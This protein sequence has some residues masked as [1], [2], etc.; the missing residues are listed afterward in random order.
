MTAVMATYQN[1]SGSDAQR[2][3]SITA[4]ALYL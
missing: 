3:R 4:A 1:A 2:Q